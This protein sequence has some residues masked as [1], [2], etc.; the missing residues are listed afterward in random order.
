M[1]FWIFIA[2]LIVIIIGSPF[3]RLFFKR[4]TLLRKLKSA[5]K[6]TGRV[7]ISTRK[8]SVFGKRKH[9]KC[10]F[11]I[12]SDKEVISVKLFEMLR[13][14][15]SVYFIQG[16]EYYCEHRVFHIVSRIGTGLSYSFKT[17]PK[18]LPKYDYDFALP[19]EHFSK[20]R[21]KVLLINPACHGYYS[22]KR[23][24]PQ[25]DVQADIGDLIGEGELYAQSGFIRYL[26]N[27]V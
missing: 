23:N 14:T 9:T 7:L 12:I 21:K 4:L 26:K 15:S 5:C 19:E 3:V 25:L 10:D 16:E 13:K 11:H 24:N 8:F 1:D 2:V 20:K 18:P 22:Y 17:K 6:K 27:N